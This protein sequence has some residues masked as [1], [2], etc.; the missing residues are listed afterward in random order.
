L[1]LDIQMENGELIYAN[2]VGWDEWIELPVRAGDL[3]VRTATR[4]IRVPTVVV[5]KNYGEMP[6]KRPRLSAG[7][8]FARDNSVCQYTGRKLPR[9]QL[10]IDHVIPK[11]R[12]GKDEW[13]N[14]VVADKKLNSMKSNRLNHEVG[15]ALIRKPVAPPALP[16]SVTIRE[17][18]HPDWRPFLLV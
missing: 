6:M 13:S 4:M 5:S 3:H 15:L 7:A 2:P 8:I 12:G 9:H 11:D 10:N 18:R 17:V 16:A 1:A 14:M